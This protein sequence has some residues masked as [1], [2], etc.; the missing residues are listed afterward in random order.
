[1]RRGL[2]QATRRSAGRFGLAT[3]GLQRAVG[4]A[5][6]AG[7]GETRGEGGGSG[8]GQDGVECV[9]PAHHEVQM[10]L[11][12]V[13]E[14]AVEDDGE[15]DVVQGGVVGG[16]VA[17]ADAAGVLAH[18]GVAPVAVGVLDLPVA[19]VCGSVSV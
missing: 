14:A 19:A 18:G 4:S 16:R 5:G 8:R 2:P 15:R 11:G 1:M 6:E 12:Q 17:G 10:C 7:E 9:A 3:V 13:A